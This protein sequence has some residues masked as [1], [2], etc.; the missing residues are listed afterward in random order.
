M[1]WRGP[2]SQ[3]AIAFY[4]ELTSRLRAIPGVT[5]AGFASTL[6][7]QASDDITLFPADRAAP[8]PGDAL[9]FRMVVAEGDYFEAAGTRIV[10][11]RAFRAQDSAA[12]PRVALLSRAAAERLFRSER[13]VGKRLM[14]DVKTPCTV[15]GVTD[16]ITTRGG[17]ER[18]TI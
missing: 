1:S 5:S 2:T 13:A 6:P 4:R 10:D 9:S 14:L 18:G 12:S 7:L 17:E 8:V 16:E 15:V 11:G 3:G